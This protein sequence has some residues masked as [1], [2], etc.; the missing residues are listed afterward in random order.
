MARTG[1]RRGKA[2]TRGEILTAA[3]SQFAAHGFAGATI[4]GIATEAK[5]DPALVHHYYGTKRQLFIETLQLP[6]DPAE[7]AAAAVEGGSE[8]AGRRLVRMLLEV[9][10]TEHG[11]AMMQSLLRSALV[12]AD[13]YGVFREF[14]LESVVQPVVAEVAPDRVALRA[15]L[16]VTQIMGLAIVRHVT[17]LEPL[18]SA[19]P[20][21][22]AAAVGPALQ[23][24]LVGDLAD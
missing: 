14:M 20:E 17:H 3:R 8:E 13:L 4:R 18:A 16:L 2:D 1:R 5:V 23:R 9:W 22:V 11:Q 24:Y 21:T 15:T 19:D 12:D 6:F 10:A 7:V